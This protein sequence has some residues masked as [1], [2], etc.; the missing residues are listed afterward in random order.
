MFH[1]ILCFIVVCCLLLN[2]YTKGTNLEAVIVVS[3]GR[4]LFVFADQEIDTKLGTG[5]LFVV[6]SVP[7]SLLVCFFVCFWSCVVASLCLLVC[8]FVFVL[9]LLLTV[10]GVECCC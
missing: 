3:F 2:Q 8:L 10:F 6:V 7:V 4:L 9:L 1:V 5:W